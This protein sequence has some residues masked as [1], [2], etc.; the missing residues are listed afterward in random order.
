MISL[1]PSQL[2][3]PFFF[4]Y[5]DKKRIAKSALGML[6]LCVPLDKVIIGT[7]AGVFLWVGMGFFSNH[8]IMR[9][10]TDAT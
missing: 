8:E 3:P 1:N 7:S 10:Y 9:I 2:P 6:Q 4:G 5:A